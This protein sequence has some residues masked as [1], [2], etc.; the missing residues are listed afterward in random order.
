[1][2][3]SDLLK[4]IQMELSSQKVRLFRNNV[5]QTETND[6]RIIRYGVCN[7]GGSDLIGWTPRKITIED[8]GKTFALF[9]AI[10]CKTGKLK[11]TPAQLNF[12]DQV[13]KAGGLAG[14]ARDEV[15]ATEIIEGFVNGNIDD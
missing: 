7:P 8:V 9:T 6:G 3:E 1:M 4:I 15:E 10:E 2:K 12:I 14:I 5:G 13:R 11:A